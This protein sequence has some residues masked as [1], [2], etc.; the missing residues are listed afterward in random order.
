MYV[1][2]C[3]VSPSEALAAWVGNGMTFSGAGRILIVDDDDDT[4]WLLTHA[5]QTANYRVAEAPSGQE[6]LRKLKAEPFDVM[7]LDLR[8][9]DM[10]GIEV[11]NEIAFGYPDL[12]TIIL[13]ANPSQDSAIA[14]IRTG[15]ADYLS[16]PAKIK[17]ILET[18]AGKLAQRALRHRRMIELGVL[19]TETIGDGQGK[20]AGDPAGSPGG[21]PGE[22]DVGR[23]RLLFDP[24]AREATVVG[25]KTQRV[26]LTK[27]ETAVLEVFLRK[28]GAVLSYQDL[29]FEAWGDRLEPEHAAGIIRPLIF[30]LRQ[31]LETD[32][33]MPAII[34]TVR[35]AGYIFDAG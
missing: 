31:K 16:K 4:R 34:R 11:L 8:L 22:R 29:A 1:P 21:E 6:A 33:S 12:I 18:I 2:G 19:G 15:V 13:T 26:T 25:R 7:L 20:S 14:A 10:Y 3:L 17:E 9:P 28:A 5:C 24:V 27:G 32:P 30:R 35:G 23:A